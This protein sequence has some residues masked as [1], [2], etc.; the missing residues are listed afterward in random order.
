AAPGS[1]RGQ[2]EDVA[3]TTI[4]GQ[5][6]RYEILNR[7]KDGREIWVEAAFAPI[8]TPDGGVEKVIVIER[9]ITEAKLRA[10]ELAEARDRAE[11]GARAKA[12]FLA[13]MSH[14][15]RTPMNGIIGM[16]DLLAEEPLSDQQK[17]YART[18]R[19]SAEALLKI[20]NDI[21]DY[22]KLE[23]DKLPIVAE[24]FSLADC[25]RDAAG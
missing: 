16:S 6:V 12:A 8:L 9:D 3:R 5:S 1:D 11:A 25:I 18:M 13:T 4:A 10:Q 2:L 19:N 14:E 21:L 7:T 15:I 22:S 24:P 23:A 17:L 20:I